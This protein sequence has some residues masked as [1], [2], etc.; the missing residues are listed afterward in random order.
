[1]NLQRRH[2]AR[3]SS[4]MAQ[5]TSSGTP[6]P[7][8]LARMYFLMLTPMPLLGHFRGSN[9]SSTLFMKG[10]ICSRCSRIRKS[11]RIELLSF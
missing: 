5:T 3:V 6:G 9:V 2:K 8:M 4:I 10:S 11:S 7:V 1:M